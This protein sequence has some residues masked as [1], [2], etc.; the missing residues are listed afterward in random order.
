MSVPISCDDTGSLVGA[1]ALFTMLPPLS[2]LSL[3]APVAIGAPAA[4]AAR[5]A[6]DAAPPAGLAD[7]PPEL[8]E[9]L[10]KR[11]DAEDPCYEVAK[12]C[13]VRREWRAWCKSGAIYDAANR[14]LGYYGKFK[15]WEAVLAHYA[16]LGKVPPGGGGRARATPRDYFQ[17]ACQTVFDLE[18][19][20]VP[21]YHPFY[22]ER[23]LMQMR[24]TGIFPLQ[25]VPTDLSNYGE[26]ALIAVG[27]DGDALRYVPTSRADYGKIARIALEREGLALRYV[28]PGRPDYG[29]LATIALLQDGMALQHVPWRSRPA[30]ALLAVQQNGMALQHYPMD[31]ADELET[32]EYFDICK[33]AVRQ[34]W[35]AL[36]FVSQVMMHG[37][38]QNDHINFEEIAWIAMK[39]NAN[40]LCWLHHD[41]VNNYGEL[42]RFALR[43]DLVAFVCLDYNF[44]GF[45][46]IAREVLHERWNYLQ[47]VPDTRADYAE[48]ALIAVLAHPDAMQFVPQNHDDFFEIVRVAMQTN[49]AVLLYADPSDPRY[50]DLAEIALQKDSSALRYVSKDLTDFAELAKIA[51]TQDGHALASVPGTTTGYVALAKIAVQKTPAAVRDVDTFSGAVSDEDYLAICEVAL[52]QD[53]HAIGLV[54]AM[55]HL[56]GDQSE[57]AERLSRYAPEYF[58]LAKLAVQK[59]ATAFGYMHQTFQAEYLIHVLGLTRYLELATIAVRGSDSMLQLVPEEHR[60]TVR[61]RV[62]EAV[63][64]SRQ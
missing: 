24:A 22:E 38:L 60:E 36:R 50:R 31:D 40:A 44:E 53:P 18:L 11:V 19:S 14:A 41:S 9:E 13:E 10:I 33:E 8:V 29:E 12:L 6:E 45:G 48:L 2:R 21:R 25:H 55:P 1:R 30:F 49:P 59:K 57:W 61:A 62:R 51:V 26:L 32:P 17:R 7:L 28:P 42:A 52:R 34:N 37:A 47:Y 54:Q 15:T 23:L 35:E 58:R 4:K 27:W 5:V 3:G 64:A 43:K 63:I 16:A 39:Q 56:I 20:N 46:E